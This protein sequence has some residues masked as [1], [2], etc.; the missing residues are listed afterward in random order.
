MGRR[1]NLKGGKGEQGRE[2][3]SEQLKLREEGTVWFGEHRNEDAGSV[4]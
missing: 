1:Y 2:P 3:G 4:A